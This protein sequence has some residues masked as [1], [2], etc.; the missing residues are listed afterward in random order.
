MNNGYAELKLVG[1]E[2]RQSDNYFYA[3]EIAA[4]YVVIASVGG[5]NIPLASA[6]YMPKCKLASGQWIV[7]DMFCFGEIPKFWT[8]KL[9]KPAAD[10]ST[11]EHLCRL[12]KEMNEKFIPT[13]ETELEKDLK[14]RYEYIAMKF[15]T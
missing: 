13:E 8:G 9:C 1:R 10:I 6:Q 15:P 2:F 12:L 3:V 14:E 11:L 4:G 7:R 5:C